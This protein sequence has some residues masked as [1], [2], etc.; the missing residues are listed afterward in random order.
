MRK[1]ANTRKVIGETKMIRKILLAGATT[2]ALAVPAMAQEVEVSGNVTLTTDYTWRGISQSN[3]DFAIQGGFDLAAGMFYAGTW[4]S[5]VDFSDADDTNLEIDLYGGVAGETAGGLG[6]DVG[7]IYYAYPDADSSDLDFVEI[8]GGL[9][10][11]LS[12]GLGLGGYLYW[13]PDNET[14]YLDTSAGFAITEEFGV[15]ATLGAYLDGFDEYANWSIGVT[16]A[17]PIGLDFDLRYWGNDVDGGGDIADD[18]IILS[19]SKSL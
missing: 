5:N 8:Y 6:W 1:Y 12:G 9:S 17:A 19:V 16:Y 14:F 15:D 7:L 3:E 11:E 13:D 18:R 4:A 10:T 2:L